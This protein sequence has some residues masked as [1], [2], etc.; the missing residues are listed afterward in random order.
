MSHLARGLTVVLL[1][2]TSIAA[3]ARSVGAQE[4]PSRVRIVDQ[5]LSGLVHSGFRRSPTFRNL[6]TTIDANRLI[7]LV[8]CQ[9]PSDSATSAAGL[10]FL[11][12]AAGYRYVRIFVRCDLPAAVLLPLLAHEFQHALEVALSPHVVDTE[13]LR[14]HYERIGYRSS[15]NDRHP[16]FETVAALDTQQRV[17]RE[18]VPAHSHTVARTEVASGTGPRERPLQ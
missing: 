13:S 2:A 9:A 10:T 8:R 18:L 3:D 4:L 15:S 1:V 5:Q 16:S 6:L 14:R 11:T 17:T 12:A 7:V